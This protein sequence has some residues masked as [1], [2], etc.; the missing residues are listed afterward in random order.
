MLSP[1]PRWDRVKVRVFNMVM[2]LLLAASILPIGPECAA[3]HLNRRL[4]ATHQR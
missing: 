4:A 2:A 1:A 3:L